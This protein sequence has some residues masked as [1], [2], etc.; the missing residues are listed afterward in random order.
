MGKQQNRRTPARGIHVKHPMAMTGV[1]LGVMVLTLYKVYMVQNQWQHYARVDS[2][3]T[4]INFKDSHERWWRTP[5]KLN[6]GSKWTIQE[7]SSGGKE[8][9]NE[10]GRQHVCKG[11]TCGRKGGD[12]A[13]C[14]ESCKNLMA[15]HGYFGITSK[16]RGISKNYKRCGYKFKTKASEVAVRGGG[17][18]AHPSMTAI[19]LSILGVWMGVMSGH[20]KEWKTSMGVMCVLIMITVP[21]NEGKPEWGPQNGMTEGGDQYIQ[22]YDAILAGLISVVVI[23]SLLCVYLG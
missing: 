14:V 23:L 2:P 5:G 1:L 15:R 11:L 22:H 10:Y 17:P 8:D 4:R 21:V 19:T 18:D 12:P 6:D 20:N 13:I 9:S 7:E 3:T 16:R